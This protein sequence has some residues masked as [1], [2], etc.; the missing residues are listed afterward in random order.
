M[1]PRRARRAGIGE[2]GEPRRRRRRCRAMTTVAVEAELRGLRRCE[3]RRVVRRR[4]GPGRGRPAEE[5]ARILAR[6]HRGGV[7]AVARLAPALDGLPEKPCRLCRGRAAVVEEGSWGLAGG[8]GRDVGRAT[9]CFK[10]AAS[11]STAPLPPA[12]GKAS[13]ARRPRP[14]SA[15]RGRRAPCDH[16]HVQL[17]TTL[18]SA[19]TFSLSQG[20]A[21]SAS[22]CR[23]LV[24]QRD[25]LRRRGR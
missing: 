16:V 3:K 12:A 22:R 5:E 1:A 18:P 6:E 15:R 13:P 2:T 21:R 24:H 7:A 4:C 14:A 10:R 19:A 11:C 8:S 17:R 25:V 9:R 20:A 23:D